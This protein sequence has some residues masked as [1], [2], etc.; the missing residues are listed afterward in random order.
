[1]QCFGHALLTRPFFIGSLVH[2]YGEDES[3]GKVQLVRSH[4][5][6]LTGD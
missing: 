1:M 4:P 6:P 5:F 3:E 2:V